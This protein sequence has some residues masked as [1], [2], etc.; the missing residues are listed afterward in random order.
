MELPSPFT[1][2]D[3]EEVRT[4]F[5]PLA[6]SLRMERRTLV[7]EFDSAQKRREFWERTNGPQIAL[8]G[9]LAEERYR[10]LQERADQLAEKLNRARDGRMVLESD[11]LLVLARKAGAD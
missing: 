4:R 7:F 1:W 10:E 3:L 2:G 5:P 9:M 8:Q 11:Y 6:A